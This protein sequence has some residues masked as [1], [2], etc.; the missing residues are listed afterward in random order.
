MT[1]LGVEC[2]G[3]GVRAS[4]D[5]DRDAGPEQQSRLFSENAESPPSPIRAAMWVAMS[6]SWDGMAAESAAYWSAASKT[7]LKET[8]H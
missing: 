2:P 6:A 3:E 1:S 8:M 4:R 5:A 7:R